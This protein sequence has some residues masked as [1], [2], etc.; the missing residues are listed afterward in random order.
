[1]G[2]L[3]DNSIVRG[4]RESLIAIASTKG[5]NHCTFMSRVR[6]CTIIILKFDNCYIDQGTL[7]KVAQ[8]VWKSL[9]A[10]VKYIFQITTNAIY[11]VFLSI[12]HHFTCRVRCMSNLRR[13]QSMVN[14]IFICHFHTSVSYQQIIINVSQL[15]Q[16]SLKT[17]L[18]EPGMGFDL[19][20]STSLG[21][22]KFILFWTVC[23]S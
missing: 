14:E 19:N 11:I 10:I 16:T 17:V 6:S 21:S 15:L 7:F 3:I 22:K 2:L 12:K 8:N 13:T 23:V 18:T 5:L 9:F 20:F 1:M 4:H